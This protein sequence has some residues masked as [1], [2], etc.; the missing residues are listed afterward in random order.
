MNRKD[1]VIN[2]RTVVG[3]YRDQSVRIVDKPLWNRLS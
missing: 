1:S 2:R 3:T